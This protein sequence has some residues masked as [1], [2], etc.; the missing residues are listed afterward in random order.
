MDGIREPHPN[1]QADPETTIS[2]YVR[3][4]QH[5]PVKL[6]N[7]QPQPKWLT[8]VISQAV[9]TFASH[10]QSDALTLGRGRLPRETGVFPLFETSE[11]LPGR[12]FCHHAPL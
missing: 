3:Q 6:I 12:L 1:Y 5:S 4:E 11:L 9:M 7:N 10:Y 8:L 2:R